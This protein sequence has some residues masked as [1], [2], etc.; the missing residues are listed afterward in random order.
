MAVELI[1][2]SRSA[3][4]IGPCGSSTPFTGTLQRACP[5]TSVSGVDRTACG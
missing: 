3:A 2:M 1:R 5:S 4:A